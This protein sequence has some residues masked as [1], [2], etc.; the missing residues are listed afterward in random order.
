MIEKKKDTEKSW[1]CHLVIL[2][3]AGNIQNDYTTI[4]SLK[5]CCFNFIFENILFYQ[6]CFCHDEKVYFLKPNILLV[7]YLD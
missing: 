4:K 3:V 7:N 5:F 2:N 1:K 6:N